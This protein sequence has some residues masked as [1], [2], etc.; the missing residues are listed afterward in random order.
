MV[1]IIGAGA[2]GLMAAVTAA[3]NGEAVRL[4][5]KNGFAG[6]KLNI[7]GKGRCNITNNCSRDEFF[8]NIPSGGRFLYS[9]F[10]Q[11][12]PQETMAFFERLGL[13]LKVERG[14]RVFPVSDNA[15]DVTNTFIRQ[16]DELGI[17]VERANVTKLLLDGDTVR[18][19][20]ASKP[21]ESD[22]VI[23]A[24][25]GLSYPLTGSTG[26]G[27]GLAMSAGHSVTP[28]SPS[29]VPLISDDDCSALQGLSLKNIVLSVFDDNKRVFS[30]QGEL[31][32][33]HTGI[34]GPLVLSASAHM[35]NSHHTAIIDLKPA[36]SHQTLDA[37][38]LRDFG[39]APNKTIANALD[40]LLPRL[41]LP[42]VL[43]TAG[44][45]GATRVNS[46]TR[47]QRE[48]LVY[49]LKNYKISIKGLGSID[50]AVITRGGVSLKEID[51]KTMRSKLINGLYFAG[52]VLDLDAYT[53]GYNL[54]IAWMT[55]R[56]AGAGQ[57][58]CRAKRGQAPEP[59]ERM[60]CND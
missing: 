28:V 46:V 48:Q 9:A 19:V 23:V 8:K 44:I 11:L 45:N 5:D 55:G 4:L 56:A 3:E 13:E 53:G 22:R 21:I 17:R 47:I 20:Y 35:D 52:E 37:R 33:T 43:K 27:Y 15:R 41:M 40:K 31:L 42:A 25:G 12:P 50:E 18:G 54:Q 16:L 1:I 32:F 14:R 36:L 2:A 10:E 24:T 57:L 59:P 60:C 29:L 26:D 30:E 39:A 51:P 7:T 58:P 34:S 6:K 38:I 49:T